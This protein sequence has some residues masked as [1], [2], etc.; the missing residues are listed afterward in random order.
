MIIDN[1]GQAEH[2]QRGKNEDLTNDYARDKIF[3]L[4]LNLE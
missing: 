3:K 1:R 4:F 2:V